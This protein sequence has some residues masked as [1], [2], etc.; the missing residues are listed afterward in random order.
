MAK[1]NATTLKDVA[2][3]AGFS[4]A[5]V[6]Y[7]LN[8]KAAEIG[9]AQKTVEKIEAVAEELGYQPNYWASSLARKST[10]IISVLLHGLSG[11]WGDRV[12]Y[13]LGQALRTKDYSPFLAVDWDDPL[14]FKKEVSSAI[15]R[16]D[17]GVICHSFVGDAKQYS[18]IVESDIPLVFVGDVPCS[19]HE[20]PGI[21]S[22]VWND[23]Q[24]VKT[25]VEH[26][27]DAGCRKIAFIGADHGVVSDRRRLAAFEEALVKA[28]LESRKDWQFWMKL[29][30]FS[31]APTK[32]TLEFLFAPGKEN[33]DALFALNDSIAINILHV[34][35][36]MGIRFPEDAALMGLGDLPISEFAGLS[37][38]REPLREL[39]EAAAQMIME[40]IEEPDKKPLH[41][42][43]TCNELVVRKTTNK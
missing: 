32:E 9:V 15:Q 35:A 11:D 29:E 14:L 28:G 40:L 39:G 3:H 33:P 25:A 37:T 18:R 21:N 38:M 36:E 24:A 8:G 26:L 1:K 13:S 12:V 19:I 5:T 30:P 17:E 31:F 27:V 16:K 34:A 20:M 4:N 41:R 10:G 22:V 42:E 6:S 43:I 23:A 2:Q 7:V